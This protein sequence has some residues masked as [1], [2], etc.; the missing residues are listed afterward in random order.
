M[1]YSLIIVLTGQRKTWMS[2]T[3]LFLE[4]FSSKVQS[5][6]LIILFRFVSICMSG[7]LGVD[8]CKKIFT[9]PTFT[10]LKWRFIHIRG[11]EMKKRWMKNDEGWRMIIWN[12]WGVFVT[13]IWTHEFC[14]HLIVK[15]VNL[16]MWL[17]SFNVGIVKIF[18]RNVEI[19]ISS[20][21]LL[22]TWRSFSQ[23]LSSQFLKT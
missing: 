6:K 13:D 21:V 11:H 7:C 14:L 9:F 2:I 12:C 23:K 3:L 18:G 4:F 16:K 22:H 19:V 8:L 20:W 1:S 17:D 10:P 5:T 15:G